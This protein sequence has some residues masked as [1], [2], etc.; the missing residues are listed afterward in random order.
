M[1]RK[2]MTDSALSALSHAVAP[3]AMAVGDAIPV[4]HLRDWMVPMASGAPLALVRPQSTDEVRACLSIC[5]ALGI[6]VVPQGGLTG[7][8]GGATPMDQCV[9]LSLDRMTGVESIDE[10]AATMTVKAGTPL[11]AVQRG[12]AEAGLF[13]PLDLGARGSCQVGGL[14]ATNAG[15]N[16]VIRYG[17]MRDLVLGLEVVLADGTLVS[18]LNHLI[19]NNAGLDVKQV[20]VGS[21]G[22]LGVI[23]RAVLRLHP[24]PLSRCTAFCALPDYPSVLR[25]LHRARTVSAG[26]LSAFEIMWPEFYDLVTS[27]TRV[28]KAPLPAGAPIY[29]LVEVLGGDQ[30]TDE[31]RFERMLEDA[32]AAGEI[33]DAAIARSD[34]EARALWQIRDAPGEFP[35]IFW[36]SVAFDIGI[37]TRELGPF[38]D[39]SRTALRA[40]WPGT[41]TLFYGHIGDANLH[42]VTRVGEGPQPEHEIEDIV[43]GLVRDWKGTISAEHGIG[44]LKQPYL[45]YCRSAAEIELIRTI[46]RALD[47]KGILNPGK[48]GT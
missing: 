19:K 30:M 34:A 6:A 46:K 24:R 43:Y 45:S 28:A 36:P 25:L 12:A 33:T 48:A 40:R 4:R 39:A 47:P 26:T 11:E 21:E 23:T 13:F 18:A 29:A 7:L 44:T 38:V 2:A 16:R 17:M 20:F 32:S 37:P 42:L 1:N 22:T 41:E 15:G 31:A 3:D 14:V 10:A 9:V 27:N 5:H 35:R 8:V